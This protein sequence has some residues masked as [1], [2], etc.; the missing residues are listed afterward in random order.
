MD[1]NNVNIEEIV[2][3]VLSG[4]TG[5]APAAAQ[6]A[7]PAAPAQGGIPKTAR[8]AMMTENRVISS[9]ALIPG[10]SLVMW[11]IS[12]TKSSAN[13]LTLL[14]CQIDTCTILCTIIPYFCGFAH[15]FLIFWRDVL[16]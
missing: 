12:I 6:T 1:M 13:L 9:F 2:K 3:Q 14:S 4:M 8:V 15:F 16:L 10:N 7:A 5:T 11:S